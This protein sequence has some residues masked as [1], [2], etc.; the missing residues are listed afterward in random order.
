MLNPIKSHTKSKHPNGSLRSSLISQEI[1]KEEV[2]SKV[3]PV[4]VER[5]PLL[6]SS[7]ESLQQLS[8]TNRKQYVPQER[9]KMDSNSP[10]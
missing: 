6:R 9:A 5:S 2:L 7:Q 8:H 3:D 10:A 1:N 4:F